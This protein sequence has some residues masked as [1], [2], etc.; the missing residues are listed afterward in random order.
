M[1][2]DIPYLT[3]SPAAPFPRV[4]A[5]APGARRVPSAQELIDIG[6]STLADIAEA[7]EN[8]VARVAAARALVGIG[9]EDLAAESGR[10]AKTAKEM[11]A[12]VRKALPE[13]ERRAAEEAGA[14]S[15][16][17]PLL[18]GGD[19]TDGDDWET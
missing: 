12:A 15:P 10:T 13:L 9:R 6:K 19:G 1:G 16:G 11:L 8:E 7:G 3:S 18:D 17:A 2:Y 14:Q 5:G 4:R